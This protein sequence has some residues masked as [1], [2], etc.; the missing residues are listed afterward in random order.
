MNV[1]SRKS[2][3]RIVW[4]AHENYSSIKFEPCYRKQPVFDKWRFVKWSKGRAWSSSSRKFICVKKQDFYIKR[5]LSYKNKKAFLQKTAFLQK[6]IPVKKQLFYNRI[7][8]Y[9]YI[10]FI[11]ICC[12][13]KRYRKKAVFLHWYIFV[14]GQLFY[15]N[16]FCKKTVIL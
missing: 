11:Y 12:V 13:K 5:Q 6:Y 8:I 2:Y 14:K 7:Y 10:Y 4:E 16:I 3:K 9:I 15:K 1:T